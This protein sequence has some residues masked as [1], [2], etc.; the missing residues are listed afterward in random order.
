MP[1]EALQELA[2]M[3]D[4]EGGNLELPQLT[5]ILSTGERRYFKALAIIN[6]AAMWRN[7]PEE[8]LRDDIKKLVAKLD[9]EEWTAI[10]LSLVYH[11][12]SQF[13]RMSNGVGVDLAAEM[14]KEIKV[15]DSM[16][17]E[18]SN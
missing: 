18:M 12:Y 2:N 5:D 6:G 17:W 16:I 13:G 8:N 3:F 1:S 14:I 9:R 4:R 10:K 11:A 15:W 7:I